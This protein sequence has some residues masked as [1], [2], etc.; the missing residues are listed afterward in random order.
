MLL[1]PYMGQMTLV[2]RAGK[3]HGNAD[4][5]SRSRRVVLGSGSGGQEIVGD[6]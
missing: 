3:I 5:L 6:S 2:H 4:G 1:A